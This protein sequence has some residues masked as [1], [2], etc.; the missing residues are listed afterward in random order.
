VLDRIG[1][2]KQIKLQTGRQA[3]LAKLSQLVTAPTEGS[4]PEARE[5]KPSASDR[6]AASPLPPSDVNGAL[7]RCEERYPNDA[8][9]PFLRRGR[10]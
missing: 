7:L 10:A 1:D 3:F 6:P 4:K 2:F 8:R 9:I 5:A